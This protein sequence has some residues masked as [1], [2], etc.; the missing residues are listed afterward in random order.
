LELPVFSV[1]VVVSPKN[2]LELSRVNAWKYLLVLSGHHLKAED[3]AILCGC[4]DDV[5]ED[6]T[7]PVAVF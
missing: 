1:E 4:E 5:V 6:R 7:D 3:K 2:A